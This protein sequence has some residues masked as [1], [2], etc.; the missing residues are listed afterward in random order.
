M[1]HIAIIVQCV[2]EGVDMERSGVV[3]PTDPV[4]SEAVQIS[5]SFLHESLLHVEMNPSEVQPHGHVCPSEIEFGTFSGDEECENS[6][7]FYMNGKTSNI[8]NPSHQENRKVL[9][10]HEL[11]RATFNRV[12]QPE[13]RRAACFMYTQSCKLGCPS[14]Y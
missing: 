5:F 12:A 14:K 4:F 3:F 11:C 2:G 1:L 8:G 7:F 9:Y 13:G 6:I 10:Y